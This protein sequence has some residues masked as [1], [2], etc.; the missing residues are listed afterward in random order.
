MANLLMGRKEEAASWLERAIAT[1]AGTR[2][3]HMLLAAYQRSGRF[4]VA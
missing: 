3:S 1:T 4:E 2:R